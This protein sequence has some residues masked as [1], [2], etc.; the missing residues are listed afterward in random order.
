[1]YC[2]VAPDVMKAPRSSVPLR[3]HGRQAEVRQGRDGAEPP[4]VV[5]DPMAIDLG[6]HLILL[7]ATEDVFDTHPQLRVE[8]IEPPLRPGE[9]AMVPSALDRNDDPVVGVVRRGPIVAQVDIVGKNSG[10]THLIIALNWACPFSVPAFPALTSA[11]V[12][13]QAFE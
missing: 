11:Q 1:M 3:Q 4:V 6:E 9:D 8:T 10:D 2:A 5:G 12:V 13:L 7:H